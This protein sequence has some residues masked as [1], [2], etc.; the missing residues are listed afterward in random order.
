[1]TKRWTKS[2]WIKEADMIR[3]TIFSLTMM[4]TASFALPVAAETAAAAEVTTETAVVL[5]A[6]TVS[7]VKLRQVVDRVLVSGLVGAVE[8][9]Q[10]APLIEGQ[11]I[12]TL[13]ADIGDLVQAGQVLATLSA[14]TLELQKS[15]LFASMASAKATI[16]QAEAQLLEAQSSAAEASRINSRTA[17]LRKQGSASQAAADTAAAN[18]VSATARVTVAVQSLEAARAQVELVIAQLANAELSLERT[19]VVAPVSGEVLARNATVGSVATAAGDPMFVIVKDNA[20]ELKA[21]VAEND[22]MRLAVG[23]AALVTSVGSPTLLQGTVRLVEPTIDA[24]SRLGRVRVTVDQPDLVRSGMFAEATVIVAD[25]QAIAVPVT[26]LGSG[27][28]GATVMRVTDGN[29]ARVAVTIGIR[30]G[31]F[32]EILDGLAPG[33][34]VV[35]KA[36]AFVRDG[37][38]INPISDAAASN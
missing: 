8:Q 32:V 38:R 12:E 35:T 17:A 26:A 18:A 5:P 22:L 30:D 21:D 29:V 10:V 20:L 6:I 34:V 1:L 27:P 3:A 11:P 4:V 2:R 19:Q 28:D 31:G 16:A 14:T 7:V 24:V 9:V 23:Q 37:D 36:G 25:R 15:Q 13:Q 33:D